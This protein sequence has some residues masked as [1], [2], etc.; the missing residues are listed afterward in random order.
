MYA[1]EDETFT[2][3][4]Y[5][6]TRINSDVLRLPHEFI[7]T[8]TEEYSVD[9]G[10]PS[11]SS[12]SSAGVTAAAAVYTLSKSRK[13]RHPTTDVIFN[14]D[15]EAGDNNIAHHVTN[16]HNNVDYCTEQ[17]DDMLQVENNNS[18]SNNN[19]IKQ[20]MNGITSEI[21]NPQEF[22]PLSKQPKRSSPSSSQ[23][24]PTC[25]T[26]NTIHNNNNNNSVEQVSKIHEN[27]DKTIKEMPKKTVG[28]QDNNNSKSGESQSSTSDRIQPRIPQYL[29]PFNQ[30]D[31]QLVSCD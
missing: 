1:E 5:S 8:S 28:Y 4:K 20:E 17:N 21:I 24:L 27:D 6:T 13:R 31:L 15:I 10:S 9:M 7:N 30:I 23:V 22:P 18:N 2:H 3:L 11:L 19:T 25:S 16:N 29:L 26:S 14:D 12:S